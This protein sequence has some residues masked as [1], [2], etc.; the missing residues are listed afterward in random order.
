MTTVR[1]AHVEPR[2][3]RQPDGGFRIHSFLVVLA[4]PG[5]RA[6][7]VWLG[8]P[9][10]HGLWQI[11][12]PGVGPPVHEAEAQTW[13][14]LQAAGAEVTGADIDE[15]DTAVTEGRRP[16]RPDAQAW[17]RIEFTTAGA[18]EPRQMQVP[19]GYALAL[20]AAFGAPVR[21]AD[22]VM[23]SL[24]VTTRGE[25]LLGEF[26]GDDAPQ[27]GQRREPDVPRFAPRNL[28]FTDGLAGWEFGG[29][30][31]EE[32]SHAADYACAAEAGT[33]VVASAVPEPEGLAAL[34]QSVLIHEYVG[35]TVTFRA[36]VRTEGVTSEA[37]LNLLGGMPAGPV[38]L[39][40]SVTVS[41]AGSTDWTALEIS[42][43]VAEH[44]GMVQFGVF[45]RGPGRVA[46]RNP[47]LSF[48]PAAGP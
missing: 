35:H 38:S 45:L 34:A 27:P 3:G 26:L 12:A 36:E 16:G 37:G 33:A 7:P 8:G 20:A 14:L 46:L 4:D 11:F 17:A 1:I 39:P 47:Q 15:L 19:L 43:R 22:Q 31:R 10:G 18:G 44:G 2:P 6:L 23:D 41:L 40:K 13:R 28:T 32:Q 30:F 9:Q 5:G 25:D 29:S 42:A 21:V 24:A 48:T